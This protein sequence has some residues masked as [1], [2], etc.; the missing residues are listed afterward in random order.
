MFHCEDYERRP[1]EAVR[2]CVQCHNRLHARF[3]SPARW[4]AHL[5]RI[6]TKPAT[7]FASYV[8]AGGGIDE[9]FTVF[10]PDPTRWWENLSL[11]PAL[12]EAPQPGVRIVL[13]YGPSNDVHSLRVTVER[14]QSTIFQP[15][16]F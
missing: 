2:I 15:A 9:P 12:K 14:D 5:I 6:R 1:V 16:L 7:P 10:T 13:S 8:A 3:S 4:Y 11:D